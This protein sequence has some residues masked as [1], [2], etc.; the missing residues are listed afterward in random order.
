ML[1]SIEENEEKKNGFVESKD[2]LVRTH[3]G[4][5]ASAGHYDDPE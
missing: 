2:P 4:Y 1:K 5:F 3:G